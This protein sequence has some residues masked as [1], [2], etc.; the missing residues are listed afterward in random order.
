MSIKEF[1]LGASVRVRGKFKYPSTG[2][3]FDPTTVK[4]S[5][6]HE[7]NVVT[8]KTYGP[9][10]E[11]VKESTGIYYIDINANAVGNWYWRIFSQGT[12]QTAE[13]GTFK[14]PASNFD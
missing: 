3:L 6:R 2:V 9:D 13:E 14:V 5:Y 11:L 12:G 8:T 7:A 1:S 4:A 10:P